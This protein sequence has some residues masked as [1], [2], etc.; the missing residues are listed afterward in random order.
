MIQEKG[1]E[2]QNSRNRYA[3]GKCSKC[4]KCGKSN[5]GKKRAIGLYNCDVMLEGDNFKSHSTGSVY[6]IR[7]SIDCRSKNVVYLVTCKRCGMQGIGSTL[8]FQG[9][10]SDYISHILSKRDTCETVEHFIKEENHSILDFSIMGIVQLE[11]PP[12]NKEKLKYRLREFEGYWQVNLNTI[13][14][15]GMNALNEWNRIARKKYI[16]PCYKQKEFEN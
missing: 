16:G 15:F 4:G 12:K 5:R 3:Q 8:C 7:Q 9:R 1:S 6:K 14:P 11:N 13:H 2:Q 10:V